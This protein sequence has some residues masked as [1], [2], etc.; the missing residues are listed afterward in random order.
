MESKKNT[1]GRLGDAVSKIQLLK[2]PSIMK[3]ILCLWFEKRQ[4]S[5]LVLHD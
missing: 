5:N 3:K 2:N 4:D 1:A